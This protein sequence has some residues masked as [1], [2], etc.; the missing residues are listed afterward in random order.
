M[1]LIN[2]FAATVAALGLQPSL[3]LAS[4][5]STH[6]EYLKFERYV[7]WG[8][9]GTYAGNEG[10]VRKFEGRNM[11]LQVNHNDAQGKPALATVFSFNTEEEA[12]V[13]RTDYKGE[14]NITKRQNP[15]ETICQ[16][17]SAFMNHQIEGITRYSCRYAQIE[18]AHEFLQYCLNNPYSRIKNIAVPE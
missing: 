16:P 13:C 10:T 6:P 5:L 9:L 8:Y 17:L 14:E 1:K 2:K 11:T 15:S 18:K 12:Q 3:G 4:D 7:A